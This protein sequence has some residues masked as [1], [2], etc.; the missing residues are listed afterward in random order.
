MG[1]SLYSD[2]SCIDVVLTCVVIYVNI[3]RGETSFSAHRTLANWPTDG[4]LSN[5]CPDGHFAKMASASTYAL[6]PTTYRIESSSVGGYWP[7]YQPSLV[8]SF[9]LIDMHPT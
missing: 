2:Q 9:A 8:Q 7:T 6:I 4:Y 5:V 3:I 1:T